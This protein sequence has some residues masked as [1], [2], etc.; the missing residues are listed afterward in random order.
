M[1]ES[2]RSQWFESNQLGT[3][4]EEVGVL[5]AGVVAREILRE[6]E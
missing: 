1:D 5:L 2:C 6:E 4:I 3:G